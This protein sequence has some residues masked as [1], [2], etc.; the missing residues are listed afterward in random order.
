MIRTEEARERALERESFVGYRY[1]NM[2]MLG[3]VLLEQG[4]VLSPLHS[5]L[6]EEFFI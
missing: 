2:M 5:C 3:R 4:E 6:Y 1:T